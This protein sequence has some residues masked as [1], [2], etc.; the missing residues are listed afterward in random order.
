MDIIGEEHGRLERLTSWLGATRA[1]LVGLVVLLLGAVVATGALWWSAL[2]PAPGHVPVDAAA[3]LDR[4]VTEGKD[5]TGHGGHDGHDGPAGGVAA[6][7]GDA[8]WGAGA[9]AT[10]QEQ[11]EL[12]VHV[13]GAVASPGVIT[14]A[15]GAR[16]ADAIAAAG[17]ATDD[18]EPHRLNL[19]RPLT[20][21]E[22]IHVPVEGEEV[23]PSTAT[24][25]E[26][27]DTDGLVDLNRADAATL[28]T[29]P[30]IGP[31][32]AEAI[33]GYREEHGPFAEPGDL[34]GVSGIGEA[35]FQRLAEHVT[36]S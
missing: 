10:A 30:G 14:V 9:P 20:D 33:V 28:E 1:E 16:V 25:P 11:A 15:A 5:P 22:Q 34:R 8:V 12:T 31:A 17:E 32:R 26:G 36:V 19:A 4:P 6:N 7:S 2:G 24:G 23:A 35:T 21:G 27:V 18:G 3:H 29:L 13:T